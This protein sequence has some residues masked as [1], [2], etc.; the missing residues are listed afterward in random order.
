MMKKVFVTIPDLYAK[1]PEAREL[2]ISNG[3]EVIETPISDWHT[4]EKLDMILPEICGVIAGGVGK[5][6]ESFFKKAKNLKIIAKTGKGLDNVDFIKAREYGISV[7][8]TGSANANGVAELVIGLMISLVRQIPKQNRNT[9]NRIWDRIPGTEIKG[10]KV[11]ILGFGA[12][13]Q[14]VAKKLSC[15]DTEEVCAYDLYPNYEAARKL[16]VKIADLDYVLKNSDIVCVHLPGVKETYRLMSESTFSI[17]KDGAYFINAARGSIVDEKALYDALVSGKLAGAA[18]DVYE[19]EPATYDSP[20]FKLDN[21]IC[22]PHIGGTTYES[23]TSD[24][25][26]TAEAI[27]DAINGKTPKNLV[28]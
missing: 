16:N 5:F 15:F 3:F 10:K 1:N 6:D 25:I 8:N 9:K 28:N 18:I 17:M 14:L 26:L 27:I 23:L 13:A 22:T 20:L 2:L 7:T 4:Y 19:K 12:I 24:C 11:G 21:V